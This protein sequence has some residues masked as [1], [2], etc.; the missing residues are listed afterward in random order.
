MNCRKC[1]ND[2][3]CRCRPGIVLMMTIVML[4]ILS[5]LGYTLVSRLAAQRHR[6]QYIIDYQ[7][8]RYACDS[9]IKY[10]L[11][12]LADMNAASLISRPNEP[13]FSDL[14]ALDD[15][16]YKKLLADWQRQQLSEVSKSPSD[17][18]TVAQPADLSDINDSI[19]VGDTNSPFTIPGSNEQNP[20]TI[21]GPYGPTLALYY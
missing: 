9:G 12:S 14:F 5:I 8:A 13:D 2:I 17:I 11:V 1:Q 15:E 20:V 6:D 16:H 19:G 3:N 7:A 4:V 21:R 10:A 18:N